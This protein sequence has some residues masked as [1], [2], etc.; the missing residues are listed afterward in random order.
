MK[1]RVLAI[2]GSLRRDSLNRRLLN[3]V[4][5]LAPQELSIDVYDALEIVPLFNEDLEDP[6]APPG[7]ENLRAAVASADG[8][9]IAT[10]EYN[11]ALPGVVKNFVDWLS[12]GDVSVLEGRP[13]AIL[14]ATPGGWGT[15]LAQASLR[16]TLAACGALVMPAPQIYLRS[17][18]QLFDEQQRLVDA[19]VRDSLRDFAEAFERWIRV[20]V[21][22]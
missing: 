19:R 5:Q 17:A 21:T 9:L 10:P 12:R 3:A 2:A 6:R 8:L 22:A 16:H 7:V 15:R 18:A 4:A 11:Q 20:H 1:T 14:G 13:T